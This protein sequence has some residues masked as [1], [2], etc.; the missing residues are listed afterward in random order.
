[1]TD[2]E[3]QKR[4]DIALRAKQRYYKL[5]EIVEVEYE[6]RYGN[7]PSEVDDDFFIDTFHQKQG[8]SATVEQIERAAKMH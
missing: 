6:R 7:H 5:T 1:M 3:F 2:K 8:N 4:I